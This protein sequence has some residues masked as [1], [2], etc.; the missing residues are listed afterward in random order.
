MRN[1][2]REYP[3]SFDVEQVQSHNDVFFL[4]YASW[5]DS[6]CEVL[7]LVVG[8]SWIVVC[9][10]RS[11]P[12]EFYIIGVAQGLRQVPPATYLFQPRA[13]L[14]RT[15]FSMIKRFQVSESWILKN[16]GL[17]TGLLAQVT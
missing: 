15:Q 12:A 7:F 1:A 11:L 2:S 9:R 13:A 6:S 17:G 16:H 8:K 4:S 10:Y 14:R 3:I 5:L